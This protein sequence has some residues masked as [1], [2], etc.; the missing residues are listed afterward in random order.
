MKLDLPHIAVILQSVSSLSLAAGFFF[1]AYQ[2]LMYRRAQH[3]ANFQK[4]VEMQM[5]LRRM[6][7]EDPSLA[8]MYEHDVR[9][10]DTDDDIRFYFMNLMQL[11]VFEVVWF[12]FKNGQLPVEY[13]T[14]WVRRVESIAREDSFKRM[15]AKPSMKILHDDFEQFIREMIKGVNEG[16]AP[17]RQA[18]SPGGG[19]ARSGDASTRRGD[20]PGTPR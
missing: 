18:T 3:V 19:P 6:R 7:V 10:L 5:Q 1:G 4:L 12:S 13:Y 17:G 16:E 9:D 20:E 8:R 2:F 15:M 11:S 14:S